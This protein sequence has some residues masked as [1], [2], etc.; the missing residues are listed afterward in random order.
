M[1]F[2]LQLLFLR[3]PQTQLGAPPQYVLRI[4][5]P[6]VA[7]QMADFA[8]GEAMAEMLAAISDRLCVTEYSI[9]VEAI[10]FEQAVRP[11]GFEEGVAVLKLLPFRRRRF[12]IEI[13]AGQWLGRGPMP[14]L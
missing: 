1:V 4:M 8:L 14:V 6:F 9:A 10:V 5:R 3:H 11:I 13:A 2:E 12:D 7:D